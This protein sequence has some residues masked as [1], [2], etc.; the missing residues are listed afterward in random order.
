MGSMYQ[1]RLVVGHSDWTARA[2]G[3]FLLIGATSCSSSASIPVQS[4]D[5]GGGGGNCSNPTP[6]ADDDY[7]GCSTCTF[8]PTAT[9]C[10]YSSATPITSRDVNA[11]CA[12]VQPPVTPVARGTNLH[13]FSVPSSEPTVD[14]GC[15]TTP[16]TAGTSQ[17]VT[18][19][20]YV[21]LFANG[22]DSSG[23]KIQI[24]Q[25]GPNGTLGAAV[26][27]PYV[28]QMT[29]TA[30]VE[31]WST[32]CPTPGGCQLR[33]FTYPNV[34]TETPLIIETSDGTGS[35]MW[36]DLY[37]YNVLIPDP[38]ATFGT[39]AGP[40][41]DADP[42]CTTG[43]CYN[44]TAVA[45]TDIQTVA[46]TVGFE[47]NSNQGLLAGEVHDCDDVRISGATVDSDQ[48]H[49]GPMFYFNDN[50]ADPLPDATRAQSG[51][52]TSVLGL[53]GALNLNT[54]T[55]IRVSATG[56]YNGQPTLLGTYVVQVYAG[57]VTALTFRGRRSFQTTDPGK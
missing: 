20:G 3:F 1:H 54:G 18:V 9:A 47:I 5:G 57:A 10:D 23:V 53:Y 30:V 55:P 2:A 52:G 36:A 35:G 48:A 46:A 49:E 22:D 11:C 13:Y 4:G 17:M 41:G 14:F 25:E 29:D 39:M 38:P 34:P 24:F 27:T 16:P 56:V 45:A 50:E 12:W 6:L 15:L 28:T 8:S 44:P 19:T 37:D 51:L 26:G 33:T 7:A 32:Q 43:P 42:N 40:A 21:K 31:T